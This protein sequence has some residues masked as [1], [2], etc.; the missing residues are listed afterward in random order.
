MF[1]IFD[2][3]LY[4]A[5][6]LFC[7]G[8]FLSVIDLCIHFSSTFF[9]CLRLFRKRHIVYFGDILLYSLHPNLTHQ[10]V[11]GLT[12]YQLQDRINSCATVRET[13]TDQQIAYLVLH[14]IFWF[15]LR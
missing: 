9:F 3:F 15:V 7:F 8:L 5:N 14:Y 1:Y 6:R 2:S 10:V 11:R 12:P 13:F 4:S